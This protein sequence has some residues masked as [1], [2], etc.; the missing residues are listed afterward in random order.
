MRKSTLLIA[1]LAAT[2]LLSG[3]GGSQSSTVTNSAA[4]VSSIS[5]AESMDEQTTVSSSEEQSTVSSAT[6]ISEVLS[7]VDD[8]SAVSS[9]DEVSS[10]NSD[11]SYIAVLPDIA[12]AFP[13]GTI[14]TID[15][16]GGDRYCVSVAGYKDGEYEKFVED[17]KAKGFTTIQAEVN[18]D[19]VKTFKAVSSDEQFYISLQLLEEQKSLNITCGKHKN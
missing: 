16:D 8:A 7:T 14:T 12:K 2:A 11:I 5:S 10:E 3:C 15:G 17:C 6:D 13:D 18:N 19:T 4:D 9:A 1:V